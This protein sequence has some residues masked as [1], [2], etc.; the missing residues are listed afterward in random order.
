MKELTVPIGSGRAARAPSPDLNLL[1]VPVAIHDG[2]APA[3]GAYA[4]GA[5]LFIAVCSSSLLMW[6]GVIYVI[7]ALLKHI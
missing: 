3:V 5:G 2:G 7:G 4:R 1:G 6:F